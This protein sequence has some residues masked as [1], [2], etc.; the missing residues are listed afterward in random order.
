MTVLSIIRDC[1]DAL[2]HPSARYDAL[3]RAR[4]RAFMAPRLLGSLVA[5]AA[6]PI[7]L[8]MRGA[9]TRARGRGLRLADRTHP[10]VLVPVAHR[11]LRRRA[12]P[13]RAGAGGPRHDGRH[14]HRRHRI[15]RRGLAHRRSPGSRAVGLAPRGRV[16][17]RAGAVMRR[18]AD[19]ARTFSLAAGAGI[20]RGPA[21]RPDGSRR[22]FR[23]ALCGGTGRQRRIA[24]AHF[25][26]VALCRGRPLS[27]ARA[28]HERRDFASQPQRRR[29]IHFAG[30]GSH[31]RHAGCP[32]HRPWPVRPRPCRRSSGL[33]HG[34]VGCRARQRATRRIPSSPRRGSRPEHFRR[35]HLGRDALPAARAGARPRP[36]SSP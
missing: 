24:G 21:R 12:Y 33:S 19:R 29:G 27:P 13:L 17:F 36:R 18:L 16:R 10:V 9:P 23:D 6:F 22:C 35:F 26:G 31:A 32:A 11:P 14:N 3:T 1:L 8:A 2:L 20:E 25:R 4:H 7:Y 30:G 15:I 28:K 34:A 5:L